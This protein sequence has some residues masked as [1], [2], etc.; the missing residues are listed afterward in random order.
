MKGIW[1][2]EEDSFNRKYEGYIRHVK[3]GFGNVESLFLCRF[4]KGDLEGGGGFL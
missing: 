4:C 1:K 3:E 2:E